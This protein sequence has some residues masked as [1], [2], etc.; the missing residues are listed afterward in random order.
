MQSLAHNDDSN[1]YFV[2][3]GFFNLWSWPFYHGFDCQKDL[4]LKSKSAMK[5]PAWE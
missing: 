2:N 5:K 1:I 4:T 3:N